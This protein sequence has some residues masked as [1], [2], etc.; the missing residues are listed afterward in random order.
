MTEVGGTRFYKKAEL[1][2]MLHDADVRMQVLETALRQIAE[3]P[4]DDP[5]T[6]QQIASTALRRPNAL[7][8]APV[9]PPTAIHL[10]SRDLARPSRSKPRRSIVLRASGARVRRSPGG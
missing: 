3:Q 8:A 2:Q 6:L 10:P 5:E 9:R 1:V 4:S 7:G